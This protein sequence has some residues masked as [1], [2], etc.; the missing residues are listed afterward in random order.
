MKPK[1]DQ[2]IEIMRTGGKKLATILKELGEMVAPGLSG[3]K[4]SAIALKK[5]KQAGMQPVLLGFEGF[6][7]VMC[8]SVNEAIVHGL[9]NDVP[10]KDGDVVKLDLTL[11]YKSLVLDSAITVIAGSSTD[12]NVTR[13]LK[14]TQQSLYAGIDA[15]KGDGTRVGDISAAV[16][17]VLDKNNL[18]VIRELVGHGIGY[19]IHEEPNVPN[20]GLAG[21]GPL[22]MSGMTI[23]IEPMASLGEWKIGTSKDGWTVKM[24]DDSLGAHFEHTVL[25]TDKGAEILTQA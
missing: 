11:G 5:V 25:I 3:K 20:Y 4:I 23:C 7:D 22:L 19:A 6:S 17:A 18:G 1:N 9:P 10:F 13:L 14:G 2:E 8:I 21:K 15:V 24:A 12:K 16:Q